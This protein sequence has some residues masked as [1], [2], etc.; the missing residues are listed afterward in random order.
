MKNTPTYIAQ[1]SRNL[2]TQNPSWQMLEHLSLGLITKSVNRWKKKSVKDIFSTAL[3]P[4]QELSVLF[5]F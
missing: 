3:V 4:W 2:I 1:I 5:D